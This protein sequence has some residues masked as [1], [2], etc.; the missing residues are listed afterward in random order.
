MYC[1]IFGM[2]QFSDLDFKGYQQYRCSVSVNFE[3]NRKILIKGLRS[4]YVDV[5][6]ITILMFWWDWKWLSL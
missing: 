4:V 5:Q 2:L 6:G 1:S 3:E